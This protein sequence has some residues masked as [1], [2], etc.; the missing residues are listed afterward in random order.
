M[1]SQGPLQF[2]FLRSF[3]AVPHPCLVQWHGPWGLSGQGS[4]LP[5]T[6]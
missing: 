6:C 3:Q 5:L 1:G 2:Q 4:N